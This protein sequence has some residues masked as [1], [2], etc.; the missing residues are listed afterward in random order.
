MFD[1]PRSVRPVVGSV[2]RVFR[3]EQS[4][5]LDAISGLHSGKKKA[6]KIKKSSGHRKTN[7]RG[8]QAGV[9]ATSCCL[10]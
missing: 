3:T 2:K 4:L 1:L 9:P 7:N 10:L 6:Y 8:L 5:V